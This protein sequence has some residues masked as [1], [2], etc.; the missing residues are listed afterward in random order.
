MK[1]IPLSTYYFPPDISVKLNLLVKSKVLLK[2]TLW[3]KSIATTLWQGKGTFPQRVYL[4]TTTTSGVIAKVTT[5]VVLVHM[6]TLFFRAAILSLLLINYMFSEENK[7]VISTWS[8]HDKAQVCSGY[9]VAAQV[10]FL[11]RGMMDYGM[12]W[13]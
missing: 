13:L 11:Q 9:P 8:F 10:Y 1:Q 2:D 12:E 6:L 4:I 5:R 7:T 3:S